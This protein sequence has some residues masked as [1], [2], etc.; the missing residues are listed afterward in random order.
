MARGLGAGVSAG[1]GV[2]EDRFAGWRQG[3]AP[4]GRRFAIRRLR[5]DAPPSSYES[6]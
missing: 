2:A 5:K 3:G 6:D 4:Q 1:W